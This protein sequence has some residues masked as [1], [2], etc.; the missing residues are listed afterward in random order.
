[1]K[2]SLGAIALSLSLL[3]AGCATTRAGQP[4]TT[5]APRP[6]VSSAANAAPQSPSEYEWGKDEKTDQL[7]MDAMVHFLVADTHSYLLACAL[8]GKAAG[9]VPETTDCAAPIQAEAIHARLVEAGLPAE[10]RE[11]VFKRFLE[12]AAENMKQF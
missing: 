5:R 4:E 7:S 10:V 9:R 8:L 12:V 11:K 2:N 1:M 6:A 3:E